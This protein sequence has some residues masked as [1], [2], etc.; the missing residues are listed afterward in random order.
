MAPEL[1]DKNCNIIKIEDPKVDIWALGVMAYEMFFGNRP[2]QALS[3]PK[4][5]N[6][7]SDGKYHI[8]LKYIKGKKISKELVEFMILCFL[9]RKSTKLKFSKILFSFL[10]KL[11][12]L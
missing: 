4:L 9:L 10:N 2:F 11:F 3:I 12:L 1:F 5:I 8:D 6:I 7:Y